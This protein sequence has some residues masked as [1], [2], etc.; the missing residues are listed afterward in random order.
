MVHRERDEE[1]E[2]RRFKEVRILGFQ[3]ELLKCMQLIYYRVFF[4]LP[5]LA[6]PP[7]SFVVYP[8]FVHP[9]NP[10]PYIFYIPPNRNATSLTSTSARRASSAPSPASAAP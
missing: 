8:N 4:R 3:D 10:M 1:E 2:I 7:P 9:L 6:T 5:T